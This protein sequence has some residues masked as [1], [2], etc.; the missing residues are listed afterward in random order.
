MRRLPLLLIPFAFLALAPL[1]S[2]RPVSADEPAEAPFIP[3]AERGRKHL[4]ET[5]YVP[6]HFDTETFENLWKSWPEPLRAEAEKASPEQRRRMTFTRYGFTA[7]SGDESGLP[8]Q[9]SIDKEGRWAVSCLA[10]HSGQVGG[11]RIEGLPNAHLALQTLAEDVLA[12]KKLLKKPMRIY[13]L[14]TA[15]GQIPLGTTVGT[16]NAVV[17]SIALLQYRDKDLNVVPPRS[18]L[19]FPHHDLDAPPWWHFKKR[20]HLYIDGFAKKGHRELMQF[21]LVPQNGR[22]K[23]LEAENDFRDIKAYLET[24]EAPKWP[25]DID[26]VLAKKGE[27]I[28]AKHCASCHGT[29]GERPTYP[30]KIVPI[31]VVGTDRLR[32]DAITVEE[33]TIY[34][35]SWFTNYDPKGVRTDPGGY[36]AP[37][38]DG[39]WASAPYLHNGSVP[40]LWHLMN[41]KARPT[42]W[43]RSTT[44]YDKERVGLVFETL[45]D[46][47]K[48]PTEKSARRE[49]FDTSKPGKSEQGHLFPE[50]LTDEQK[51]AVL[52]YLKTL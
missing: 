17:F 30:D 26:T 21:M 7:R 38:L 44:G 47:A 25:H 18:R 1:M 52:E 4:L 6:W 27:G 40:T 9:Y 49:W 19:R 37:P 50:R 39:I 41:V 5:P 36:V 11:Q 10:C 32:L 48:L 51:R 45:D 28:F 20:T 42:L 46:P 22:D 29:Y 34:S 24:I 31:D 33:R 12:T 8:E 15:S 2:E 35:G 43:K 13:D 23:V 3:S 14:G 16:T